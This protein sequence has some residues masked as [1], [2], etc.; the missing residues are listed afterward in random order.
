VWE[1]SKGLDELAKDGSELTVGP[2]RRVYLLS[3]ESATL[4]RLEG[5][6]DA[7][8]SQV[9]EDACWKLPNGIKH[10]EGLIIDAE[11]HPWVAVDNKVN[12]G[13]NLFRLSTITSP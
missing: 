1:F 6:L 8:E 11:M 4:I 5:R 3:Q 13:S 7:R 9:R 12:A 10:A 2:D